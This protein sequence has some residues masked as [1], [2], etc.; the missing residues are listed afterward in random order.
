MPRQ[1]PGIRT[2]SNFQA[3]TLLTPIQTPQPCVDT[4]LRCQSYAEC[5][6]TGRYS[7]RKLVTMS[8]KHLA[9]SVVGY[10]IHANTHANTLYIPS[11]T[12]SI[13]RDIR[14]P[15]SICIRASNS[16]IR[17]SFMF[18]S[19]PTFTDALICCSDGLTNLFQLEIVSELH[20]HADIR[21]NIHLE[22]TLVLLLSLIP[23][24]ILIFFLSEVK[25]TEFTSASKEGKKNQLTVK[26]GFHITWPYNMAL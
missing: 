12:H 2:L 19:R 24:S 22:L 26:V 14:I 15:I 7:P 21:L 8:P 3:F 9:D 4:F 17:A 16:P 23:F 25:T 5:L 20:K 1:L 10:L 11:C 18:H 6:L 13:L